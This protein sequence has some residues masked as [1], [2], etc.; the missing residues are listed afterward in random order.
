MNA[1]VA[2]GNAEA[3][4]TGA[5]G[6]TSETCERDLYL[7]PAWQHVAATITIASVRKPYTNAV[8]DLGRMF[9]ACAQKD[10]ATAGT[11][12]ESVS[13]YFAETTAALSVLHLS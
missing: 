10:Y 5:N 7:I 1:I 8:S 9:A 13:T 6:S 3:A 2:K 11:D 4:G 12:S